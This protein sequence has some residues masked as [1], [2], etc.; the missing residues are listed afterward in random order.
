MMIVNKLYYYINYYTFQNPYI[1]CC[2]LVWKLLTTEQ[3][4]T[5]IFFRRRQIPFHT[6]TWRSDPRDCKFSD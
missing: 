1:M 5:E 2:I 3:Q 4:R 6:G